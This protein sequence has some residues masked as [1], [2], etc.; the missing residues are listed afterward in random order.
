MST[1]PLVAELSAV[2]AALG[3]DE[4]RVMALLARRLLG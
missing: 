3:D 1:R 4:L 2:L